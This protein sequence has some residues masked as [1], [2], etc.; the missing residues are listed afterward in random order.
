MSGLRLLR[1]TTSGVCGHAQLLRRA[2]R[3]VIIHDARVRRVCARRPHAAPDAGSS[4]SASV[5]LDCVWLRSHVPSRAARMCAHRHVAA[6]GLPARVASPQPRF[7][8]ALP[9]VARWRP[10]ATLQARAPTRTYHLSWWRLARQLR[11]A[12]APPRHLCCESHSEPPPA[13]ALRHQLLRRRGGWRHA[14]QPRCSR[15][16]AQQQLPSLPVALHC[17]LPC[18]TAACSAAVPARCSFFA[19]HASRR[20]GAPR[21]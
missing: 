11:P 4:T 9:A 12:A 5:R 3:N 7:A 14:H 19:P 17:A 15:A 10:P 16:S 6:H 2:A 1:A 20:P 18:C 13:G 21:P 8:A